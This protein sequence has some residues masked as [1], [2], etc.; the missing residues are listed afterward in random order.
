MAKIKKELT[1]G[2]R[3]ACDPSLKRLLDKTSADLNILAVFLFGSR[4][5]QEATPSSDWD[6]C[7]VL[8]K[9]EDSPLAFSEKKISYQKDF[10]EFDIQILQQLPL[11]I[12]RRIFAEGHVLFAR[13]EDKLYELAYRFVREYE[14]FRPYHESYLEAVAHG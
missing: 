2:H 9:E 6:I 14:L 5:R 3:F 10:P 8:S 4:A 13:D 1:R 7:L 11:A 12:R